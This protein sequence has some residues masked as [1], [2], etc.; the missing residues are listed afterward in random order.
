[1]RFSR[2]HRHGATPPTEVTYTTAITACRKAGDLQAA[3][4]LLDTA[5]MDGMRPSL[6]MYSATIWAAER[7]GD[8]DVAMDLLQRMRKTGCHPN[9]V[10]YSG[11]LSTMIEAGQ[12]ERA[13]EFVEESKLENARYSD[14]A[15]LVCMLAPL[16]VVCVCD[17]T[18]TIHWVT[19][20]TLCFVYSSLFP[21]LPIALGVIYSG[22][23]T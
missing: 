7:Y 18:C 10:V 5:E 19:K 14:K 22:F 11:V 13:I 16:E 20:L 3:L 6:F 4:R 23:E 2:R 8:V 12:L 1:M 21:R 17:A 15:Y 9:S